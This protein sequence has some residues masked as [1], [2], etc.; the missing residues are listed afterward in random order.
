MNESDLRGPGGPRG[1]ASVLKRALGEPLSEEDIV[2]L[3]LAENLLEFSLLI[4]AS[5]WAQENLA[6]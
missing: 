6:F 3:V 5:L 4:R 2:I 1:L